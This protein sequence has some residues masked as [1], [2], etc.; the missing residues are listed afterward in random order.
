MFD[1]PP[2]LLAPGATYRDLLDWVAERSILVPS[3]AT[4]AFLDEREA[5]VRAGAVAP[6]QIGLT[7]G[8]RLLLACSA[9][10]DGGRILTYTEI[11]GELVRETIDVVEAMN[12]E[13]RFRTETLEDQAAFLVSLAEAAHESARNVEAARRDLER[14]VAEQ[15]ELEAELRRL[16]SVDGLTG[17][18]NHAAFI[19]SAQAV[20]QQDQTLA[21]LMLDID[22][23]KLINDRHGHAV[24]DQA[25]KK[26]TALLRAETREG[27]LVGRM[28]GEEFAVLIPCQSPRGAA[29]I[30]ER[31]RRSVAELALACGDAVITMTV[32]IGVALR[33][34]EDRTIEQIIARANSALYRAKRQDGTAW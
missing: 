31:L 13:M 17:V 1:L 18:L 22:H 10:P 26:L 24:G 6:T 23:F 34:P 8:R 28:G 29:S 25:L 27:D 33:R 12:A 14:R 30:A 11:S 5:A 20:L 7:D 2:T 21:V 3:M 15:H 32:S 16:A 19:T 4:K 9:C